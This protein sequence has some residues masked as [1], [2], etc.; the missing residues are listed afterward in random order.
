MHRSAVLFIFILSSFG[1]AFADGSHDVEPSAHRCNFDPNWFGIFQSSC[2]QNL[3]LRFDATNMSRPESRDQQLINSLRTTCSCINRE[4]TSLMKSLVEEVSSHV[5]YEAIV[6]NSTDLACQDLSRASTVLRED[7]SYYFPANHPQGSEINQRLHVRSSRLANEEQLC[8][9]R[10]GRRGAG[11]SGAN[12]SARTSQIYAD[13]STPENCLGTRNLRAFFKVP[14]FDDIYNFIARSPQAEDPNSWNV[15]VIRGELAR[16]SAS[17]RLPDNAGYNVVFDSTAQIWEGVSDED[18]RKIRL[19]T[20]QL[21]FL[22]ANPVLSNIMKLNSANRPEVLQKQRQMLQRI[23]TTVSSGFDQR[24]LTD[25]DVHSCKT[26]FLANHSFDDLQTALRD[27]FIQESSSEDGIFNLLIQENENGALRTYDTHSNQG[28]VGAVLE[29]GFDE[30]TCKNTMFNLDE[31]STDSA[32]EDCVKKL[33][34]TC[35]ALEKIPTQIDLSSRPPSSDLLRKIDGS[36]DQLEYDVFNREICQTAHP[37][38][39]GSR[40]ESY[41]QYEA[42]I[43][44]RSNEQRCQNGQAR[45]EMRQLILADYL[46]EY[47]TGNDDLM[48]F[49][50]KSPMVYFSRADARAISSG[51]RVVDAFSNFNVDLPSGWN[52]R[53]R[54]ASTSGNSQGNTSASQTSFRDQQQDFNFAPLGGQSQASFM[55]SSSAFSSPVTAPVTFEEETA[56]LR[57]ARVD[58]EQREA[59]VVNQEAAL[60][61]AREEGANQ[62]RL[63]SMERELA[64]LRSSL[65]DSGR[66]YERLLQ[67]FTKRSQQ[68]ASASSVASSEGAQA[69]AAA[70][71][72][73]AVTSA[74]SAQTFVRTPAPEVAQ[75]PSNIAPISGG[76]QAVSSGRA[77]FGTGTASAASAS[78]AAAAN[79][80]L[81]DRYSTDRSADASLVVRGNNTFGSNVQIP[82]SSEVFSQVRSGNFEQLKATV[83]S[84]FGSNAT[85]GTYYLEVQSQTNPN[86]KTQVIA[87]IGENGPEIFT[88][89]EYALL[90]AQGSS[91]GRAPA[92]SERENMLEVLEDLVR[93]Q[94]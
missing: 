80:A 82:V 9:R 39:R 59:A 78:A 40:S 93:P 92:S 79:S 73:S 12:D 65:E 22:K 10:G 54:T 77:S 15:N 2:I 24:C 87:V 62:E 67:D 27:A 34:F 94:N 83:R 32:S 3:D 6:A 60:A 47:N 14:Q 51:G 72:T 29:I 41:V 48:H 91:S 63:R 4:N 61:R 28:L 20:A 68:P 66:R 23:K 1:F 38:R 43:C 26:S 69:P 42:R 75:A 50:K 33:G 18:R 5:R 55:P 86:E 58:R 53:N 52:T 70:R 35:G 76:G 36:S 13:N 71:T 56:E 49:F 21:Q 11:V 7:L 44:A 16:L 89:A 81:A 64:S 19:Y 57:D 46:A 85:A 90:Q 45:E 17:L 88:P 74:P 30:N 8:E 25:G 84:Q 31:N 37:A